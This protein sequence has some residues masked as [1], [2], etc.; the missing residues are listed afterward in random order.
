MLHAD[1]FRHDDDDDDVA[2]AQTAIGLILIE[3]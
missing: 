1:T 3:A 2:L